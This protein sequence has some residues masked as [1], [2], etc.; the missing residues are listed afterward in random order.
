[1]IARNNR[2]P[3]PLGIGKQLQQAGCGMAAMGCLIIL[4]GPLI[5][6]AAVLLVAMM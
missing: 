2:R 5:V 6:V 4:V 3:K 1:M